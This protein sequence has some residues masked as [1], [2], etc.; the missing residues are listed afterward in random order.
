LGGT[1]RK[2]NKPAGKTLQKTFYAP[3][4]EIKLSNGKTGRFLIDTGS[5][6]SIIGNKLIT[7]N[8]T[9]MPTELLLPVAN[10]EALPSHGITTLKFQCQNNNN[11]EATTDFIIPTINGV[12]SMDK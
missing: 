8:D 10:N 1:S 11:I 5:M 7:P 6:S 3:T 4:L 2:L 12:D 9:I